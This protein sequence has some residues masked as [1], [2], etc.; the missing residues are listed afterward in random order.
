MDRE[1]C[2]D[3]YEEDFTS[4]LLSLDL[5]AYRKDI[6]TKTALS[7]EK[8]EFVLR[9]SEMISKNRFRS[10][11]DGFY[12]ALSA[13]LP[14]IKKN[15]DLLC[16]IID[17]YDNAD[18]SAAQES[19]DSL[20]VRLKG[21][22]LISNIYWP[23]YPTTFFRVRPAKGVVL[24]RPKDLFHIPYNKRHLVS[25]ERYSMAG[26]PCLYLASQLQIAWQE[27]GCPHQYY[28]SE[29]M[30]QRSLEPEYDW[31]FITFLSPREAATIW[32][33]A[34]NETDDFYREWAIDYLST[35]PL[36]YAC[37][38]VNLNGHSAFKQEFVIPQMLMQWIFRNY[39]DIKG[40]KYFSCYNTD[41]IRHY[42]G[43]NVAM[44]AKTNDKRKLYSEDLT[45]KFKV[46]KPCLV[47]N[48]LG[49]KEKYV[50]KAYKDKILKYMHSAFSEAVE[51]LYAMYE[52]TDVL[53][54]S[55]RNIVET[56]MQ[57][58]IGT[59][60]NVRS[61]GWMILQKYNKEAIIARE[62]ESITYTSRTELQISLF[63]EIYDEFQP[64]VIETAD[65]FLS[66]IDHVPSHSSKEF[67]TI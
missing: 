61:S 45:R 6:P 30:Y 44:P 52:L 42:N 55:I 16:T 49:K 59:I 66:A 38:I 33:V 34:K 50:V 67:Y 17:Y 43:Y 63:S 51:C 40:I 58:L 8:K 14:Q 57:L 28:Y 46:S 3:W 4:F 19:F 25:N 5:P 20:M 41:D 47:E 62:R 65:A 9:F 29:F 56:D 26:H 1:N 21:Q 7:A 53:D 32:L 22:L 10:F 48:K 24:T 54:K 12:N 64:S 11:S 35:Y 13:Q 60:R 23:K 18:L 31:R 27:C 37:S 2:Y 15:F 39:D 36:I